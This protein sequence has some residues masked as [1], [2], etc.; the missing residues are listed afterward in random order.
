VV[1]AT[2]LHGREGVRHNLREF[3][4]PSHNIMKAPPKRNKTATRNVGRPAKGFVDGAR[5]CFDGSTW[6][7]AYCEAMLEEMLLSADAALSKNSWTSV[8]NTVNQVGVAPIGIKLA[9][10]CVIAAKISGSTPVARKLTAEVN[11]GSAVI[12]ASYWAMPLAI[13]SCYSS[14]SSENWVAIYYSRTYLGNHNT[15]DNSKYVKEGYDHFAQYLI[16]V[17]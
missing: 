4:R 8:G 15:K 10:S 17:S 1:R 6:V 11:S 5:F 7:A 12:E 14:I 9:E 16:E 13:S 3:M 2:Y